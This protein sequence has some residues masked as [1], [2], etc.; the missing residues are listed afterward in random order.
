MLTLKDNYPKCTLVVVY[1]SALSSLKTLGTPLNLNLPMANK[2]SKGPADYQEQT[3]G[4]CTV[5][6]VIDRTLLIA[7][8][9]NACKSN[10]KHSKLSDAPARN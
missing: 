6:K 2:P 4:S 9:D 8:L 3:N 5:G 7:S 10:L 1:F